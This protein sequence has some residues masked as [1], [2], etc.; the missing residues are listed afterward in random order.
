MFAKMQGMKKTSKEL[1]DFLDELRDDA[2]WNEPV[3]ERDIN[4]RSLMGDTALHTAIWREKA[5][6]IIAE[7]IAL[8][9]NVNA[10]GEMSQTPLHVAVGQGRL[11]VAELLLDQGADVFAIDSVH[12]APPFYCAMLKENHEMIDLL[13]RRLFSEQGHEDATTQVNE[14]W[15]RFHLEQAARLQSFISEGLEH[16]DEA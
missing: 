15:M 10:K 16:D 4:A 3:F 14:S 9:V 7:I 13:F 6:E 1:S 11:D 12:V 2:F 8:G 5:F